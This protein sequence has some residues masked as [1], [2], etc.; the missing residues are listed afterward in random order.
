MDAA[1]HARAISRMEKIDKMP[2]GIR[3]LVHE[4]G[5]GVVQAFL[6]IGVTKP[7]QIAHLIGTV[8]RGSNEVGD[9]TRSP[10]QTSYY[11]YVPVEPTD[12]MIAASMETC[13]NLDMKVTKREKHRLRLVAAIKAQQRAI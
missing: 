9:R 5:L 3:A 11:V 1:G 6:D 12:R 13:S 8:Q 10:K 2:E 7:K 4:Y